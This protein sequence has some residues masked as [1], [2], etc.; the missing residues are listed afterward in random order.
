MKALD[1]KM[2]IKK[3]EINDIRNERNS[4][5][6]NIIIIRVGGAHHQSFALNELRRCALHIKT[7]VAINEGIT[8]FNSGFLGQWPLPKALLMEAII[9]LN[10]FLHFYGFCVSLEP[11]RCTTMVVVVRSWCSTGS[12]RRHFGSFSLLSFI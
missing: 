1:T 8:T 3:K 6:I 4:Q 5:N 10:L 9:Y 12:T 7:G 11:L 2:V